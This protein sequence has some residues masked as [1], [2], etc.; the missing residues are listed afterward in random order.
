[1]LSV[2]RRRTCRPVPSAALLVFL[3]FSATVAA[4]QE[5]LTNETVVNVWPGSFAV[6]GAP[7]CFGR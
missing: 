5:T 3:A 4:Q 6:L 1:M 7:A 2:Q